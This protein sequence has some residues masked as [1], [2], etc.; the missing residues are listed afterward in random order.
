MIGGYCT[1]IETIKDYGEYLE[2]LFYSLPMEYTLEQKSY[3]RWAIATLLERL[4]YCL[5]GDEIK[6]ME[7]LSNELDAYYQL[8]TVNGY[9]FS[10]AH[11]IV[12]NAIDSFY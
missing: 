1:A 11:E 4:E 10:I 5:P 7:N 8:N 3:S 2:D 12:N 6:I 9:R